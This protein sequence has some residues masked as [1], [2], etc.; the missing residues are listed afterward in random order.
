MK[1]TISYYNESVEDT[2]LA[3]PSG[4]RGRYFRLIDL[5]IDNGANLGG[6]RTKHIESD[7]FEL[8]IRGKE[9]I[10]R[11]MYCTMVDKKIVMLHCFTKKT[12]KTPKKDLNIARNRL[13][14][15]K[16]K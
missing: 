4:L 10:A 15:V 14:E 9:G 1:W 6:N 11:V 13:K 2:V 7:L 8:R 12:Q 3:L 16:S 5:M